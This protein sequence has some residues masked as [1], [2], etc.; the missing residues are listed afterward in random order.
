MLERP[1]LPRWSSVTR[2][3][4]RHAR[5]RQRLKASVIVAP[6]EIGEDVVGMLVRL[7]WITERDAAD[8]GKVGDAVARMLRDAAGSLG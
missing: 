8:R 2:R 1:P 7:K 4:A 3:R 6:V 5:Y